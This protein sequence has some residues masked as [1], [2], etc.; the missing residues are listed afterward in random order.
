M[1]S[2]IK[3]RG[4]L[5]SRTPLVRVSPSL[6]GSSWQMF[7]TARCRLQ[8]QWLVSDI[9]TTPLVPPRNTCTYH[10]VPSLFILHILYRKVLLIAK[11]RYCTPLTP[12]RSSFCLVWLSRYIQKQPQPKEELPRHRAMPV[13]GQN[14]Y[15]IHNLGVSNGRPYYL[16][17]FPCPMALV[18]ARL[19]H[20]LPP[21][22]FVFLCRINVT[23]RNEIRKILVRGFHF[24]RHDIG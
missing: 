19:Q 13:G 2:L 4:N 11:H 8:N 6:I 10:S 7:F 24:A 1:R 16:V 17:F 9:S 21:I 12:P 20:L 23:R 18:Q 15:D 14:A 22:L 5:Y 3:I